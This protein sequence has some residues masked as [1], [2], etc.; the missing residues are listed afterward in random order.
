MRK[1]AKKRLFADLIADGVP[2]REAGKRAGY[3]P[4]GARG[5]WSNIRKALG[6]QAQL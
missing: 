3:T 5:T 6:W 2:V 1:S 4:P